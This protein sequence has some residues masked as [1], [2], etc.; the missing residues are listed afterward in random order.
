MSVQRKFNGARGDINPNSEE[1]S[2]L[3]TGMKMANLT[4]TKVC[5]VH[6]NGEKTFYP[7][8]YD[9]ASVVDLRMRNVDAFDDI[10]LVEPPNA[11]SMRWPKGFNRHS[12]E[13][14][15]VDKDVGAYLASLEKLPSFSVFSIDFSKAEMAAGPEA[16]MIVHRLV[17]HVLVV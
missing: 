11:F 2:F 13:A 17:A 8:I 3:L 6:R 4:G 5:L 7:K 15:L 16:T 12:F 1:M 10:P 9:P 14:V